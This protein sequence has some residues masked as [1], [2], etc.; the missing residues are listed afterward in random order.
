MSETARRTVQRLVLA[1]LI[2]TLGLA[3]SFALYRALALNTAPPVSIALLTIVLYSLLLVGATVL[4][5][6]SVL[7]GVIGLWVVVLMGARI[8]SRLL[9]VLP[10]AIVELLRKLDDLC[11]AIIRLL[12]SPGRRVQQWLCSFARVREGWHLTRL[13]DPVD[14]RV[15]IGHELEEDLLPATSS[16][17]LPADRASAG[18][19]P[20]SDVGLNLEDVN[21]EAA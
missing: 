4:I 13:T 11:W 9:Y 14:Q 1:G 2:L 8:V 15:A 5:S 6:W 7:H 18:A 10:R 19:T 12:S 16:D 17:S 20:P 3:I 21:G